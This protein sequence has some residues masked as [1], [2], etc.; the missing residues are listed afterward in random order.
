VISESGSDAK[1]VDL[2]A[3]V[4]IRVPGESS[5]PE[6]SKYDPHWWHDPRNAEAAMTEIE[7]QLSAAEPKTAA[8]FAA[9]RRRI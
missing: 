8:S 9:T 5:G 1:L 7:R 6:A 4:P 3:G 2:G